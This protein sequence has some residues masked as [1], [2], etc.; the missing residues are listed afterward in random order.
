MCLKSISNEKNRT[1]SSRDNHNSQPRLLVEGLERISRLRDAHSK[2]VWNFSKYWQL[3]CL[4]R[5]TAQYRRL[6]C[7]LINSCAQRI[8]LNRLQ[9]S[10]TL[11][12]KARSKDTYVAFNG[13]KTII[14][15]MAVV[16]LFDLKP[17]KTWLLLV[18]RLIVWRSISVFSRARRVILLVSTAYT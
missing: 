18:C 1:K 7:P 14:L 9:P 5:I 8:H 16:F 15:S 6:L 17:I 11:V 3:N 13:K 4:S 2:H 10:S 12:F